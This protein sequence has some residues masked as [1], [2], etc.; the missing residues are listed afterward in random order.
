MLVCML[1]LAGPAHAQEPPDPS[2]IPVPSNDAGPSRLSS[3]YWAGSWMDRLLYDLLRMG[4]AFVWTINKLY[5]VASDLLGAVRETTANVF[6][7][8]LY[9][10]GTALLPVALWIAVPGLI[11]AV[12]LH[13]LAPFITAK[14]VSVRRALLIM[15]LLP[16]LF[17]A[18][19]LV[20]SSLEAVRLSLS[21]SITR[22]VYDGAIVEIQGDDVADLRVYNPD[23]PNRLVD[24]AAATLFVVKGDVD[25]PND[26]LPHGFE[27]R[28]FTPAPSDWSTIGS[29]SR[30]AYIAQAQTA[31]TRMV[32]G[33]VPA[34]LMTLDAITQ[35]LWTTALGA[36]FAALTVVLCFAVFGVFAE[37][38][39]KIAYLILGVF[40]TSCAIS[41]VQGLLIALL[42]WVAATGR[43]AAIVV[44]ALL[45]MVIH[46]AFLALVLFFGIRGL[47]AIG[48]AAVADSQDGNRA[49]GVAGSVL[50]G[51]V[52]GAAAGSLH[53]LRWADT[54]RP[55][56]GAITDG[57]QHYMQDRR[58]GGSREHALGYAL[59]PTHTGQHIAKL[60]L[61]AGMIEPDGAF[62]RG[63]S[64]AAIRDRGDLDSY[65]VINRQASAYKQEQEKNNA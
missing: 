40:T 39:Y 3:E 64:D 32:Y 6:D 35:V 10:V 38:A 14:I 31:L 5:F 57:M 28:Y 9:L 22:V 15:L 45:L 59:G 11:L 34:A 27:Q 19:G 49:W 48:G 56:M 63:I 12:I 62:N 4:V 65:K 42:V 60:G 25:A 17:P 54:K 44:V 46:V 55:H 37:S 29:T 43:A 61:L 52:A 30:D 33:T 41:A 2:P 53:A 23:A 8:V 7:A 58:V 36:L 20:F 16:V 50:M 1:L 18:M 24:V 13:L 21:L 51:G 47:A 26:V